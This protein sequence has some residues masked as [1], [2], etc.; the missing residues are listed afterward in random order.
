MLIK[1]LI[2]GAGSARLTFA[3]VLLHNKGEDIDTV[4]TVDDQSRQEGVN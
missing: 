3:N 2:L 4:D 1:Y